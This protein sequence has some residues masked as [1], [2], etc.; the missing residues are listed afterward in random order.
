MVAMVTEVKQ[1]DQLWYQMIRNKILGKV[2]KFDQ[3]WTKILGVAN[4]FMV[5]GGGGTL[6]PS[7]PPPPPLGLYRV[8]PSAS[9]GYDGIRVQIMKIYIYFF[10][11][12]NI[13]L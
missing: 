13:F 12:L 5:G 3:K 6:C 11:F 8:K 7:P 1:Y 2:T 4:R 10:I 9:T